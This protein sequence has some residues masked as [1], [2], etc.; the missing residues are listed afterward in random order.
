M[1]SSACT[2]MKRSPTLT[3]SRSRRFCRS[4]TRL[5]DFLQLPA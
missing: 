4:A 5:D 2:S 3:A 1:I